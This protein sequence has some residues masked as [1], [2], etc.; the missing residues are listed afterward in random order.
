MVEGNSNPLEP[1]DERL[2]MTKQVGRE[3]HLSIYKRGV[4]WMLDWEGTREHPGSMSS[5]VLFSVFEDACDAA[6]RAVDEHLR[7]LPHQKAWSDGGE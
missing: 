4:Y 7:V 5:T 2:E 3:M 1:R 6:G